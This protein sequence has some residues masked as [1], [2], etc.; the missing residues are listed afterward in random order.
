MNK[1][2]ITI[3]ISLI[4]IVLAIMNIISIA[5]LNNSIKDIDVPTNEEES[6]QESAVG[7]EVAKAMGYLQRYSHK[8]YWAGTS[9]NWALSEFYAHELEETFEEIAAAQVTDDGIEI[10]ALVSTMTAPAFNKIEKAIESEDKAAFD[11]SY[12]LLIQS[13]NA[14]HAASKHQFIVIETPEEGKTFN[15]KF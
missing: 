15:Q 11:S 10:S 6:V 7:Y 8:L 9:E 13:C 4:A 5:E 14:C 2:T 3:I 12:Q 1:I